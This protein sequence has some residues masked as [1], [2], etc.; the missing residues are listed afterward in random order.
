[1][2]MLQAREEGQALLRSMVL[3]ST[4]I[5]WEEVIRTADQLVAQEQAWLKKRK[6][7]ERKVFQKQALKRR[8]QYD[9]TGSF[10]VNLL[11]YRLEEGETLDD[12]DDEDDFVASYH[13]PER[14]QFHNIASAAAAAADSSK[15]VRGNSC[16]TISTSSSYAMD[17]HSS[18]DSSNSGSSDHIDLFAKSHD[19]GPMSVIVEETE[20]SSI[21]GGSKHQR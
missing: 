17:D 14:Y 2:E 21:Q 9:A 12:D 3:R 11:T 13:Q 16:P 4:D 6:K 20:L 1:M 18:Y 19:S 5:D 10:S 15:H 8:K 7:K